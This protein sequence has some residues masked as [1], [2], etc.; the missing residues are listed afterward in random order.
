MKN[1]LSNIRAC[2]VNFKDT[3]S[4]ILPDAAPLHHRGIP[5]Q[6][7]SPWVAPRLSIPLYTK[8]L[9]NGSPV[10]HYLD[11]ATETGTREFPLPSKKMLTDRNDITIVAT[12][13]AAL[14]KKRR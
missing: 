7:S 1:L 2:G 9:K 4:F 10:K 3:S 14:P 8:V 12:F 5:L 6:W 13:R 11:D